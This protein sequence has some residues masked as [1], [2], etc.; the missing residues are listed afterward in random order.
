V[1]SLDV[2][3]RYA[4][5]RHY[6]VGLRREIERLTRLSGWGSGDAIELRQVR[7]ARERQ[8]QA[9]EA[10]WLQLGHLLGK[11]PPRPPI[12]LR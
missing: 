12:R 11:A 4:R 8:L 1:P 9:S 2:Q 3:H 7:E 6:R 5:L 10:E